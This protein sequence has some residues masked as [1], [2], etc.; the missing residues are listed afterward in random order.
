MS[1]TSHRDI[2]RSTGVIGG[3]QVLNILFGIIRTKILAVLLGPGGFGIAGMYLSITSVVGT[4]TGLGIRSS[5][6]RQIAEAVGTA[7]DERIARTITTLRR[8]SVI[9]GLLGAVVLALAAFP[10]SRVSFG[11]TE[12]GW[13]L[14]L[15]SVTLLFASVAGG[16]VALIQGLRRIGD[17][18]R[19]SVWGAFFGTVFNIPFVYFWGVAGIAPSLVAVSAASLAAS[20]WYARRVGVGSL[21][22]SWKQIW[23]EAKPL[24]RLGVVFMSSALMTTATMYVARVLVARELGLHEL[25]LYQAAITLAGLYVGMVLQA[26][27]ADF[28][29]RLTA[30][31]HE[32]EVW[33]RLVNEQAEVGLLVAAPGIVA[34][35]LFAPLVISVFYSGDFADAVPVLQWQ[36]LGVLLQ[37]TAWPLGFILVA[38]GDG[39]AYFWSELAANCVNMVLVFVGITVFGLIGMGVAFFTLYVVYLGGM[40]VLVRRRHGFVWSPATLHVWLVIFPLVGVA[41]VTLQLLPALWGSVIA[42]AITVVVGVYSVR[43]LD[44]ALGTSV[45]RLTWRKLTSL[46]SRRKDSDVK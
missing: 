42:G 22:M 27:G 37:L 1:N 44:R 2:L 13:D 24:T 35:M 39:R 38:K 8:V 19:L 40:F 14:V 18:A 10:L 9:T 16:Q 21:S 12:H 3:S 11:S 17:L 20:W 32:K 7:D 25:G 26:M 30:A 15:L 41:F 6:V 43:Q 34:T 5:G 29:P 33:P 4:A 46:L 23:T 45:V 31:A 28:Y 36:A